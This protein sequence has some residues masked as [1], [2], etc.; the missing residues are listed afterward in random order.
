[1]LQIQH[2][3]DGFL[4]ILCNKA[5]GEGVDDGESE[6]DRNVSTAQLTA[7]KDSCQVSE[8]TS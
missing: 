3:K 7:F 4:V 6:L 2:Y 5:A 8:K 1:M